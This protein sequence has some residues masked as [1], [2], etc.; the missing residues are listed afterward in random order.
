MFLLF[1]RFN[2]ERTHYLDYCFEKEKWTSS[3]S[4]NRPIWKYKNTHLDSYVISLRMSCR[5]F[6]WL[7]LGHVMS[8]LFQQPDLLAA[9]LF[10][11]FS[12]TSLCFSYTIFALFKHPSSLGT[13][14]F[15][16]NR[17]LYRWTLFFFFFYPLCSFF[18]LSS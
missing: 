5:Q 16:E 9:L 7:V 12:H 8:L 3:S 2:F 18:L 11:C 6:F 10:C 14:V 4:S 17:T 13:C 1:L 15:R